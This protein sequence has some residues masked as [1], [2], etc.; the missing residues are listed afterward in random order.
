MR[1]VVV[2]LLPFL[3][4][5]YTGEGPPLVALAVKVTEVPVQILAPGLAVISIAGTLTGFTV[6]VILLLVAVVGAAQF[7]LL[8]S[9]QVITSFVL[10]VLSE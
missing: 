3:V 7:A 1:V 8:V 2:S 5:W 4:H 6:M 10:S 9:T